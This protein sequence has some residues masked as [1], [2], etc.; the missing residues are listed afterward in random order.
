[1]SSDHEIIYN[2]IYSERKRTLQAI[3]NLKLNYDNETLKAIT[4]L[5]EEQI[6][7]IRKYEEEL[8]HIDF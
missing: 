3:D 6:I 7:G 8:N 4:G 1:M 5:S 2:T